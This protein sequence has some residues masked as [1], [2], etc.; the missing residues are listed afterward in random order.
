MAFDDIIKT[1]MG[2]RKKRLNLDANLESKMQSC[3]TGYSYATVKK[4]LHDAKLQNPKKLMMVLALFY[5][6]GGRKPAT[7]HMSEAAVFTTSTKVGLILG[8][9]QNGTKLSMIGYTLVALKYC[10]KISEDF[11]EKYKAENIWKISSLT[12]SIKDQSRVRQGY[13]WS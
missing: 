9:S 5:A 1:E 12:A 4:E 10:T 8:N 13:S 11:K 6:I 2:L 3:L 7:E